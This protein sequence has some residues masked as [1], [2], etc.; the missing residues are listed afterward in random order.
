M[1]LKVVFDPQLGPAVARIHQDPGHDW[2]V[3]KLAET[4]SMSRTAFAVRFTEVAGMPPLT[5]VTKWRMIGASEKI[6]QGDTLTSI[7]A[8]AGYDS[9]A[10]FSRAFKREM[11]M[12]PGAYRRSVQRI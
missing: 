11:D 12:S 7:A 9:D 5:Y 4:V 3:A 6:R 10:A 8:G 2:T 1:V